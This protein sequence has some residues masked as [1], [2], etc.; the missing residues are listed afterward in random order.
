MIHD[1]NK[2]DFETQDVTIAT[3]MNQLRETA[4]TAKKLASIKTDDLSKRFS[5]KVDLDKLRTKVE[6]V[7]ESCFKEFNKSKTIYGKKEYLYIDLF[8]VTIENILSAGITSQYK[9]CRILYIVSSDGTLSR[10]S[11]VNL[12]KK[13]DSRV[14]DRKLWFSENDWVSLANILISKN[15][16]ENF[17]KEIDERS[18]CMV[19]YQPSFSEIFENE[20]HVTNC[21]TVTYQF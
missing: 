7:K 16:V 17:F 11:I 20:N 2:E 18:D 4:E 15:E 1:N 19:Q 13:D 5:E 3:L 10:Y 14:I 21:I 12:V 9:E 6:G 8:Y